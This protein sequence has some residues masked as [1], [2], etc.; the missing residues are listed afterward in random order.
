MFSTNLPSSDTK[1]E[2]DIM[3]GLDHSLVYEAQRFI[4]AENVHRVNT[5][6]FGYLMFTADSLRQCRYEQRLREFVAAQRRMLVD[7]AY[8]ADLPG[9]DYD[10]TA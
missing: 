9:Q 10:K 1:L 5:W 8:Q 6:I 2:V 3:S 7:R 4:T